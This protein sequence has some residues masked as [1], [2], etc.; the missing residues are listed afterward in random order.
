MN[1]KDVESTLSRGLKLHTMEV[2]LLLV[3]KEFLMDNEE[4]MYDF[5]TQGELIRRKAICETKFRLFDKEKEFKKAENVVLEYFKTRNKMINSMNMLNY[6]ELEDKM[7]DKENFDFY[8]E[9]IRELIHK[10]LE[11][12]KTGDKIIIR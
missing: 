10:L 7:Q 3:T 5:F 11:E 12:I 2:A 6:V 9:I 8:M 4:A 1:K